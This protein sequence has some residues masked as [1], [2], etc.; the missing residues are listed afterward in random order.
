LREPI[1]AGARHANARVFNLICTAFFPARDEV[2]Q[3]YRR[4]GP[5][6]AIIADR[7]QRIAMRR[8][9]VRL[10][11]ECKPEFFCESRQQ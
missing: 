2:V 8:E 3:L 11:K 10:R 5:V 7:R 6:L 1:A 9:S 4:P